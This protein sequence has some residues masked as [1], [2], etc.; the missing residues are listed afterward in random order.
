MN[1]FVI[2]FI[3][4]YSITLISYFFFETSGNFTRRAI[5]KI[6][7]ASFFLI[8]AIIAFILNKTLNTYHLVELL[9]IIFAFLG[10]V[11]LLFSFTKGGLAFIISNS[12]FFIYECLLI[13][14]HQISFLNLWWFIIFLVIIYGGF[15]VFNLSKKIDLKKK[16]IGIYLYLFS[17]TLHS[18][19]SIPLALQIKNTSMSLLSIGLVLFMISDYFLML[20]K[21]KYP[22]KKWILRTNSGTYF[23]GLLLVVLSLIY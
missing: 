6:I 20:H 13:F 7:L 8:F 17:V 18:T 19:L 5:N 21:F 12:L 11:I 1:G 10:D 2:G 9:A 22:D 16:K 4:I 3:I 15:V 14:N 23:I